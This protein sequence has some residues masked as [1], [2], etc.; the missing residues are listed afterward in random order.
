MGTVII[1]ASGKGGT[2]KTSFCCGTAVALCALGEK[3]LLVDADSGLRNLDIVLGMTDQLLFSFSDVIAGRASLKEAA[4][5]HPIVKN[6]RVLT[7]PASSKLESCVTKEKVAAFLQNCRAHFTYTIVD[8]P[9]GLPDTISYFAAGGDRAVI[10]STPDYTSLRGAEQAAQIFYREKMDNVRIVVNR[11]RPG[12]I[13]QGDMVNIDRAMDLSGLG[14]FGGGARGPGY[15]RLRQRR[16][17]ADALFRRPGCHRLSEH[18]PPPEGGK[19]AADEAL[20]KE[21]GS[22][23]FPYRSEKRSENRL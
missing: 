4:V 2:G 16:K 8:C 15:H 1:T 3:V 12:M 20:K 14:L 18:R 9:A 6:L 23:G 10:V 19:G 5:K 21:P 17:S 13:E 11:V 7:A 22:P